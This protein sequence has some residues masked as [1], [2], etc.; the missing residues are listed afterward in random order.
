MSLL[1]IVKTEIISK[2]NKNIK[3]LF[4]FMCFM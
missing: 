2:A 3:I 4:K 1:L